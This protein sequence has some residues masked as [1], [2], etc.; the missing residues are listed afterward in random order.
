MGNERVKVQYISKTG[1]I[2]LDSYRASAFYAVLREGDLFEGMELVQ[3]VWFPPPENSMW[4]S[5][6]ADRAEQ[7]RMLEGLLKPYFDR[8]M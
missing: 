2:R 8:D 4:M 7:I 1:P 6:T 3:Y 5:P